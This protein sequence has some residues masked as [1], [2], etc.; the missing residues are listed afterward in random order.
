MCLPAVYLAMPLPSPA[1]MV[2]TPAPREG[3]DREM[4][5]AL[6]GVLPKGIE[7][8]SGGNFL[9]S[10]QL[11][12][13]IATLVVVGILLIAILGYGLFDKKKKGRLE[14]LD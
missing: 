11:A 7:D 9:E 1:G 12:V 4:E 2:P 8:L 14:D 5:E 13:L 6:R 10:Y 3:A